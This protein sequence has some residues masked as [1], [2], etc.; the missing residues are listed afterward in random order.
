VGKFGGIVAAWLVRQ[1]E[2][3]DNGCRQKSQ[4]PTDAA[5]PFSGFCLF[6]VLEPEVFQICRLFFIF[7][8]AGSHQCD[9][10]DKQAR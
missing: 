6:A 7:C 2:K 4:E 3:K 9:Y 10:S 8:L 5:E 1:Q